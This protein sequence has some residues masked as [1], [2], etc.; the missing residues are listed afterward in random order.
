MAESIK[1]TEER[2][3]C[4]QRTPGGVR[5]TVLLLMFLVQPG[6]AASQDL[7][8]AFWES[9]ECASARELHLYLETYPTGRYVREARG[10]LEDLEG[11]LGLDR[12]ERTLVQ[13]GLTALD[14]SL[15][16]A[17][18]L[19][20]PATR[21]AIREWQQTKEYAATGYLTR[22]QAETLIDRGREETRR[23][24][25]A[26]YARA[27][28]LDTVASYEEYL[29]AYPAGRHVAEAREAM[30]RTS[31]DPTPTV[32]SPQDHISQLEALLDLFKLT[33]DDGWDETHNP[34]FDSLN[35][36]DSDSLE[37]TL[38]EGRMYRVD[39]FCD[40][41]CSDIDL[42]LYDEN[43]Q[44]IS[45]DIAAD[46][47][48]IVEVSPSRTGRFRL[49]VDMHSCGRA[50]CYYVIS[51]HA[52]E[53]QGGERQPEDHAAVAREQRQSGEAFRDCAECPELVVVPE[54][55]YLMGS[56]SHEADRKD[57][58]G[59]QHQVTITEPF[60]VGVYEVTVREFE[61]FVDAV[62]YT[63]ENE[64]STYEAGRSDV[65][66]G[67]NW[68]NPGYRQTEEYPV[69]CV[70]W[71]DAWA[72]VGWLSQQTGKAYRLLSEAEWE[73][74]ARAGT[75]TRYHWGD[76][77]GRNLANCDGCGS[78]WDDSQ[79]AP[80]GSFVANGWG[81]YDLHGNV[82]E[83]VADCWN[84]GYRGA[85]MDGSAWTSEAC[86]QPVARGGS[87]YHFPQDIRSAA[88]DFW[89]GT[90]WRSNRGGFRIA[91]SLN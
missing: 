87:W 42:T 67:R 12:T 43:N 88:R 27:Q 49:E 79:A 18:G 65:R 71:D 50:P 3:E 22:E 4:S 78:R 51:I 8:T 75:E 1:N 9:V 47:V 66:P 68:Q 61:R 64:C 58:E 40:E 45:R 41:D 6:P 24:D 36:G 54:G 28:R 56:P 21:R 82:W 17:D 62:G 38:R 83:W 74:V 63:V 76:A 73:Y 85:P 53:R 84:D 46:D 31:P 34:K 52:R 39:A 86:A 33:L 81:V 37:F 11:E 55:A 69:V 23:A 35:D 60:A 48:P 13:Q 29:E 2:R 20:G 44:L 72:Y 59:P 7:E 10:C 19:F 70:S 26:A 91:R 77:V 57:N 89:F 16:P 5:G 30:E 80:V 15:G 25:D 14:Y 32:K 90:F